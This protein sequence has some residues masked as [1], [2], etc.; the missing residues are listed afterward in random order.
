M[1][2]GLPDDASGDCSNS[3]PEGR[4]TGYPGFYVRV[5][6]ARALAA[7]L[8][9]SPE[10]ASLLVGREGTGGAAGCD[11][12]PPRDPAAREP[13]GRLRARLVRHRRTLVRGARDRHLPSPRQCSPGSARWTSGR[14]RS[15]SRRP[16]ASRVAGC[17]GCGRSSRPGPPR[18][19]RAAGTDPRPGRRE[20]G[21]SA[22][23]GAEPRAEGGVPGPDARARPG[24][25]NGGPGLGRGPGTGDRSRRRTRDPRDRDAAQ[26]ARAPVLPSEQARDVGHARPG[27]RCPMARQRPRPGRELASPDGLLPA[28]DHRARLLGRSL[29]GLPQ[30]GHRADLARLRADR[31]PQRALQGAAERPRAGAADPG[32]AR[33]GRR[34]SRQVRARLLVRRLGLDASR[35]A[36][37]PVPRGDGAGDRLQHGV[38]AG[39]PRQ[40]S[41]PGRFSRPIPRSTRWR[42][43]S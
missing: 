42:P 31:E 23:P 26:A 6:L 5:K 39:S 11:G 12:C 2:L 19:R 13:R 34:V 18:S 35:L 43:A 8:A 1:R 27:P 33:A 16:R 10:A 25:A 29:A 17:A 24:P 38:P 3:I 40:W 15:S 22:T 20:V 37:C 7:F 36:P 9:G 14:S 21:R 28:S 4:H 30:P 32:R 41:C